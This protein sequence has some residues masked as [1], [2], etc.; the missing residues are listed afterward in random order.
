M[1]IEKAFSL[2][3]FTLMAV[4]LSGCRP[5]LAEST[6]DPKVQPDPKARQ[7]LLTLNASEREVIRNDN[8]FGFKLFSRLAED[9]TISNLFVSPLSISIAMTMVYNGAAGNTESEMAGVLGYTGLT[10]AEVN[11]F[12]SK[13][14]PALMNADSKV[15][16]T[17][18]NSIWSSPD[19]IPE[20]DFLEW[21]KNTF[22]AENRTQDL[23]AENTVGIINSWVSDKTNGLITKLVDA[24][25]DP[26][27]VMVLINALYFKGD[28]TQAFD[29][30]RTHDGAFH[31]VDGTDKT[32][33]M[34]TAE[35][36]FLY[37]HDANTKGI[38]LPYGDSLFSMALLQPKDSS[39]LSSLI[40]SLANGSWKDISGK[41]MPVQG[42]VYIP[43]FKLE[44][45]RT[46]EADLA[47]MGMTTAFSPLADLSGIS[48]STH[49][50]I[51]K[52]IHKT[53]ISTD[54]VGT[55]AAAVTAVTIRTVSLVEDLIRLDRPFV[56]VIQ[57]RSSGT[58]LFLGRIMNPDI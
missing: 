14:I 56:V 33:R 17:Q 49:L 40:Q 45:E 34:M 20:L 18:A 41:F 54:E 25:F 16:F 10:R 51:S 27:T 12:Y 46:I 48:K 31:L 52:V 57:E 28:W 32:C 11:S 21:N 43:K 53:A 19:L 36:T 47:A 44:Y 58:I 3:I 26:E 13:L 9:D 24:P 37:W 38:E 55:I 7:S 15:Q 6:S 5:D 29:P 8:G 22:A 2:L 23:T 35:R 39:G 42:T 30:K 50:E 1:N 4:I